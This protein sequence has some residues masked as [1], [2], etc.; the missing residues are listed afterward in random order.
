MSSTDLS[1]PT[2]EKFGEKLRMLRLH[3]GL[4]LQQMASSLGMN[5]H[6]YISE[7]EHGKKK[8]T[9]ELVLRVA[10]FFDVTTDVLLKDQLNI[11]VPE[12]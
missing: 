11:D 10:Y 12:S 7:L 9:A 1:L 8:P 6:G 5:A 4:T 3:R 2:V